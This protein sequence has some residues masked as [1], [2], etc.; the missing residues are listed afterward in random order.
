MGLKRSRG[1]KAAALI[2]ALVFSALLTAV[3]LRSPDYHGL[4]WISFLPLFVVV[5][6]LRPA[7]ALLVG[8]LWGAC[9]YLFIT[10]GPAPAGA[11]VRI[12]PSACLLALL[13]VIPAV[14]VGLAARPARALGFKLLTLALGWI[15]VEVV[16]HLHDP[17][18]LHEGLLTGSPDEGLHLHWLARL[19]GY[20]CTALIV[21]CVNTSLVGILSRVRLS[22][23]S[24]RSLAGSLNV[25][26]RLAG[27]VV[28][29]I[30]SWTLRQ[31]H[32]RAPPVEASPMTIV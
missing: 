8:G 18:G 1:G 13:I 11:V 28:Q 22:F 30:Q 5:R 12:A 25:M 31:A 17:S 32:P 26:G 4:A 9:L 2:V 20:V 21:A 7:P 3:A 10:V 6:W 14:Y 16:L 23:P 29:R 27:Q 24:C 15:L 19:V